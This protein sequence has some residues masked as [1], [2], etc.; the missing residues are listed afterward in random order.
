MLKH[1]LTTALRH[2]RQHKLTTSINVLCLSIGLSC[3]LLA[4]VFATWSQSSDR[5]FANADRIYVITEKMSVGGVEWAV[6]RAGGMAARYVK[7][8]FPQL[9]TVARATLA[10]D[11]L[12]VVNAVRSR[13]QVAYADPEFLS[14]FA[15]PFLAGDAKLALQNPRGVV[16]TNDAAIRLFGSIANAI[17]HDLLLQGGAEPLVVTGVIGA[18]QQPS[19]MGPG[20]G[21]PMRFDLLVA[22]NV[23]ERD[24]ST[25]HMLDRWQVSPAFT[26]ALLPKDG[27]LSANAFINGLRSFAG[28]HVSKNVCECEFG[29]IPI[30]EL[31]ANMLSGAIGTAKTGMS[32]TTLLYMICGVVLLIACINYSNLAAA[33]LLARIK[34]LGVR[35]VVGASRRQIVTQPLIEATLQSL[36]AL[37]IAIALVGW[38]LVIFAQPGTEFVMHFALSSPT[39]WTTLLLAWIGVVAVAGMYPSLLAS[40]LNPAQAFRTLHSG[41][42]AKW[43]MSTLVGIQFMAASILLVGILVMRAQNHRVQRDSLATA[44]DPLVVLTG[45]LSDANVDPRVLRTELLRQP[46]IRSVSGAMFVP[47][48]DAGCN[49]ETVTASPDASARRW[50]VCGTNVAIDF[51]ETLGITLLAG[52]T[53]DIAHDDD[54]ATASGD[55]A[56]TVDNIVIDRAL[57]EQYG[58]QRPQDAVGKTIYTLNW[59]DSSK[60][61]RQSRVVGVVENNTLAPIGYGATSYIYELSPQGSRKPIIR[62]SKS[63]VPAALR[64]INSVWSKL[65]PNVALEWKFADEVLNDTYA[66]YVVISQVVTAIAG[67][68]LLIAMLGLIGM[69]IQIIGRRQHEIGVRKTLGASVA[70]IVRLL[71]TD[72]SKPVI[73]ANALGWPLAYFAIQLYLS[74]FTQRTNITPLPFVLGLVIT[75]LIAWLAVGVQATR[76]ARMNPAAVLRHE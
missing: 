69:S 63:D 15:L 16:I 54:N 60:P 59:F 28:R 20:S 21:N 1:Y 3:F 7:T 14:V 52:R 39:F 75:I 73:V 34:E 24:P 55:S 29:A 51:F 19:H 50:I 56:S 38:A 31:K 25:G 41:V 18:I 49:Q 70:G 66:L 13:M 23:L 12:V 57:A 5:H 6:P 32:I 68:A 48:G 30:S 53:L 17:G 36:F 33:L 9:E 61:P 67:L 46:H 64:E 2:F 27:A 62:I 65:S 11:S 40:R 72:F 71:V 37:L 35:R 47:W 76:A 44:N 22:M 42:S 74:N 10:S 4:H 45:N 43:V 8:D 26:Y 58:W